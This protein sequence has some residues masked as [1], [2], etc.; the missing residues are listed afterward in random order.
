MLHA[1]GIGFSGL[2]GNANCAKQVDHQPVAR[3]CAFRQ[4]TSFLGTRPDRGARSPIL[5]ASGAR[6]P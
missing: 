1:F 6:W 3:M 2:G 5:P 4:L